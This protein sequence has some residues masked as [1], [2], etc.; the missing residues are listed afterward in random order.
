MTKPRIAIYPGTFDPLTNGHAGIIRRGAEIFD[1]VVV[2]VAQDNLKSPLFSLEE[3]VGMARDCFAGMAG[4]EVEPF[5]GLLVDYAKK[6][7]ASAILRGLR[8]LSDFDYEFQMALMNRKLR[9]DIQTVF[10]M[11]DFRWM[12]ISSTNIKAVASLGGNV[13]DL[14][15]PP[16]LARL[17]RAYGLPATWPFVPLP[18]AP[19]APVPEAEMSAEMPGRDS[20]DAFTPLRPDS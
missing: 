17:R 8:A 9:S 3:R 20:D 18:G 10:L 5:S 15:P 14:V 6:R 1:T 2:A 7:G 19:A 4:I 12:Y 13:G 16:V 11:S